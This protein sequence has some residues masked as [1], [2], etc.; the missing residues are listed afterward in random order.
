VK[1]AAPGR[2]RGVT[3]R[4]ADV[5]LLVELFRSL[6]GKRGKSEPGWALKRGRVDRLLEQAEH[7]ERRFTRP[8]HLHDLAVHMVVD[9]TGTVRWSYLAVVDAVSVSLRKNWHI[10]MTP[11]QVAKAYDR[12]RAAGKP[13]V[14]LLDRWLERLAVAEGVRIK[15][16]K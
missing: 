9:E 3:P 7:I 2:P 11:E 6:Y 13:G 5:G 1:R 8:S 16:A 10:R 4:T 14:E 15:R 12:W